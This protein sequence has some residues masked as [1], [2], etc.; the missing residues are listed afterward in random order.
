M[1]R[2]LSSSESSKDKRIPNDVRLAIGV[3]VGLAMLVIIIASIF[4]YVPSNWKTT[5]YNDGNDG[6]LTIFVT[7][8]SNLLVPVR[9][10]FSDAEFYIYVTIFNPSSA[11]NIDVMKLS[12]TPDSILT[13]SDNGFSKTNTSLPYSNEESN[14]LSF[15]HLPVKAQHFGEVRNTSSPLNLNIVYHRIANNNT[16]SPTIGA[17]NSTRIK[18]FNLP[19][20]IPIRTMD[21]SNFVYLFIVFIGVLVSRYTKKIY[22]V[23][24]SEK[25]N[26]GRDDKLNQNKFNQQDLVWI[27]ASGVITLLIFSSFQQQ[28]DL[29]SSL[30]INISLAF[31][32]GF[33]FDKLIETATYLGKDK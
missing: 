13:Y 11:Y 32:F 17:G 12:S 2:V 31:T 28:V 8:P 15:Y 30:I 24:K 26:L 7:H 3:A 16:D 10:I 1:I 23:L 33:G 20:D 6:N 29:Q 5:R 19:L 25:Q 27:F 9:N 14:P 22:S 4:E 18:T 21:L